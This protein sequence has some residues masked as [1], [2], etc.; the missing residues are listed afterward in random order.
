MIESA[1]DANKVLPHKDTL[2]RFF[3]T[4]GY[5]F[6]SIGIGYNSLIAYIYT[7]N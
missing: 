6:K 5:F 7:Y 2:G 4:A 3:Y 1:G